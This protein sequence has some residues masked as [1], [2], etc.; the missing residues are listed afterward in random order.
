MSMEK[1]IDILAGH[2]AKKA[3]KTKGTTS[4]LWMDGYKAAVIWCAKHPL[5]EDVDLIAALDE[6]ISKLPEKPKPISVA[7]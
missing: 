1:A 2:L 4:E 3:A 6:E 7:E 5:P